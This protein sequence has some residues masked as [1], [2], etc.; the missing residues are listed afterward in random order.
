VYQ[1]SINAVNEQK[2]RNKNAK[3]ALNQ[4]FPGVCF[5]VRI[6]RLR[7]NKCINLNNNGGYLL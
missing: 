3:N 4:R 5:S 1:C 7:I 6:R 2:K